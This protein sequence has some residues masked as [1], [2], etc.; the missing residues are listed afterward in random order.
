MSQL[1]VPALTAWAVPEAPLL[2]AAHDVLGEMTVLRLLQSVRVPEV[3]MPYSDPAVLRAPC[4]LMR[5]VE[6]DV[7]RGAG[8]VLLE[9]SWNRPLAGTTDDPFFASFDVGVPSL[10][11]KARESAGC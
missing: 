5:Q 1:D 11:A 4:H 8:P 9:A 2:P 6:G 10:L 3:V 7:G